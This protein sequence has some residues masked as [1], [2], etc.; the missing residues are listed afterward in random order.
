MC[1][2]HAGIVFGRG[3]SCLIFSLGAKALIVF[4]FK[5]RRCIGVSIYQSCKLFR[6]MYKHWYSLMLRIGR[7]SPY[8]NPKVTQRVTNDTLTCVMTCKLPLMAH[9]TQCITCLVYQFY[10]H[11]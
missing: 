9:K 3:L 2:E 6:G 11:A 5:Q 8:K 4:V 10:A 1:L 7:Y